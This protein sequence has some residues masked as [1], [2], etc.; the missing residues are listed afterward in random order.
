MI[1]NRKSLYYLR[2]FLD[3]ILLNAAFLI[4]AVL[5][6][7][8]ELLLIRSHMF[9]LLAVNNFLWYF[10]AN[11]INFYDDFYSQYF[12]YQ[13]VNVIKSAAVQFLAAI[14]FLFFVKEPSFTRN[15]ML[16]YTILLIVFVSG[17]ILIL[18]IILNKR[19][20]KEERRRNAVVIGTGELGKNFFNILIDHNE[21][22]YNMMGFLS[23]DDETKDLVL[24]KIKNID[25]IIRDNRIETA[26]I[27]L[28]MDEWVLLD[29]VIRICNKNAVKTY[30]IPDYSRFISK[31]FQ[32]SMIGNFPV[33]AVRN[34]PLDEYNWRL[35]KRAFDILF[36]LL[37]FI[38]L[39]WW[40]MPLVALIIKIDSKGP[41]LFKQDRI[42]VKNRKFECYKFRTMY[43]E[44]A[45]KSRFI[46]VVKGDPR[47]TKVGKFLRSTNIDELPQ[48]FNVIKGEMS[49]VGPRPHPVPHNEK[50][51]EI[52]EAIKLRLTVK[53]GLTGWAQIHGLR[54]DVED[55]ELNK[56][57]TIK[58]IEF[59][60]WYIENWSFWL[61]LQIILV[62]IWQMIK[63]DTSGV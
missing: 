46:P 47:I 50:Y 54:G 53:P 43:I 29:E 35:L 18:K 34:E 51:T 13:L 5:N 12:L 7:S 10:V 40:V 61:D 59:D 30:I 4:A 16:I 39:L 60:L 62:T 41:A 9:I 55:S 33:I 15:Y 45:D 42:G 6:Q 20:G 22:G 14:T 23:R 38:I 2:L 21:F 32:V 3:L 37:V 17:R 48:F 52:Y 44:E 26:F 1:V 25:E 28:P 31:K 58:R 11:V 63:G 36:S 49:I 8:F 57:R 19:K 27:A 24:G 56:K